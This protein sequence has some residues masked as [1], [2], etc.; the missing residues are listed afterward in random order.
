MTTNHDLARQIEDLVRQHV[1][2]LRISAAAA[3][4]RAFAAVPPAI[5][6]VRASTPTKPVRTRKQG[7][8][9]RVPAE[10][11]AL[12]ERF[13]AVLCQRPGETMTTLAPQVGVAPRVLQVAVARLR[14]DGR[15]RAIGKRQ[16]TRYY[17][18]AA[19]SPSATTAA[20]A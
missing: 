3:V 19:S 11:V 8:P 16:H 17:P 9:R 20:A 15:V 13:Y 2:A 7:A 14:R 4:A 12:G 5:S 6:P 1:D 18:M 10:L